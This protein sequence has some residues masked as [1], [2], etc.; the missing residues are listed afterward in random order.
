MYIIRMMI[1]VK[2]SAAVNFCWGDEERRQWILYWSATDRYKNE[3][4]IRDIYNVY[5]YGRPW[6]A[7]CLIHV[8]TINLSLY[9]SIYCWTVEAIKWKLYTQLNEFL[10]KGL[11]HTSKSIWFTINILFY[12]SICF[13]T[14]QAIKCIYNLINF[15]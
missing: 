14:V 3:P 5:K 12:S 13:W 1:K 8:F 2:K 6:H 15:L 9:T 7:F 10:I 11:I 4:D